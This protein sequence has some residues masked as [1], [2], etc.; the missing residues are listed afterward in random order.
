M[1]R[2]NDAS[3]KY[4]GCFMDMFYLIAEGFGEGG[5][6]GENISL[7]HPFLFCPRVLR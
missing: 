4:G 7:C 6:V 5:G 1:I 2:T 3:I